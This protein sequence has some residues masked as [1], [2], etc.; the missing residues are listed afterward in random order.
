[1]NETHSFTE[2]S[3][4]YNLCV[5]VNT[6][7]REEPVPPVDAIDIGQVKIVLPVNGYQWVVGK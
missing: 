7:R 6:T 3:R 4:Y 2:F 5:V 1:M